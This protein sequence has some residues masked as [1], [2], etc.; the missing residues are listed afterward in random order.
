[1]SRT[2]GQMTG[3][4]LLGAFFANRLAYHAGGLVDVS[5]ADPQV[6]V[7]AM[8]DQFTLAAGLIGLGLLLSLVQW[9]RKGK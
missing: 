1:M 8:R 4:A 7:Q 9:R 6:I 2:L 5:V 3:I